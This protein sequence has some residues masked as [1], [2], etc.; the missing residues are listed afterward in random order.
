MSFSGIL[1]AVA[2]EI[3]LPD[4]VCV[5]KLS[6]FFD[7]RY[8]YL[9][10][11]FNGVARDGD[12]QEYCKSEGWLRVRIRDGKGRFRLNDDGTYVIARIE[13]LIEPYWRKLLPREIAS[14]SFQHDSAAALARA[15]EKRKRKAEKFA[16]LADRG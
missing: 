13:G 3:E 9:G 10:V 8:K 12:V 11:K 16:R 5:D 6:P 7:D 15:E 14:A 1:Q 4:R 2:P